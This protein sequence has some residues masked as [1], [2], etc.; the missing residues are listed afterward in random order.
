MKEI[1]TNKWK[2]VLCL[3]IGRLN[4]VNMSI[5]LRAVERFKSIYRKVP[6]EFFFFTEIEKV[7]LKFISN[8]KG[9]KISKVILGKAKLDASH[10]L[11][12]E[13]IIKLQ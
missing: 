5:V 8:C 10:F 6:E 12:S 13:L 1:N 3:W 2:D 4:S 11:I 9:P 7:M